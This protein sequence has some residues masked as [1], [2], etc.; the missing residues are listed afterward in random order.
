MVELVGKPARTNHFQS[1]QQLL[2]TL[3]MINLSLLTSKL[4]HKSECSSYDFE[5]FTFVGIVSTKYN[6]LQHLFGCLFITDVM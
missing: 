6:N 4:K 3:E 5:V 2:H 1:V